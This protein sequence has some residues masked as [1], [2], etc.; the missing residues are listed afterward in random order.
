MLDRLATSAPDVVAAVEDWF[1]VIALTLILLS[2]LAIP[3]TKDVNPNVRTGAFIF[4]IICFLRTLGVAVFVPRPTAEGSAIEQPYPAY[5][6]CLGYVPIKQ[7]GWSTGHKSNYC[8]A[9]GWD[10]GNFNPPGNEYKDG[11]YCMKGDA[12]VCREAIEA[13]I[14]PFIRQVTN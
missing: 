10:A 8:R 4:L 7:L 5:A 14:P 9:R 3:M 11:G 12:D 1:G 13:G 2:F 6:D